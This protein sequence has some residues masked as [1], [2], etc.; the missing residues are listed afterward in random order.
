MKSVGLS[1]EEEEEAE[2]EGDFYL[3]CRPRQ[4]EHHHHLTPSDGHCLNKTEWW[5]RKSQVHPRGTYFLPIRL[6]LESSFR[7]PIP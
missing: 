3:I 6:R 7:I 4:Q 2:D 5:S 1:G